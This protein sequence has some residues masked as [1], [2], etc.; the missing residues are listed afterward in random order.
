MPSLPCLISALTQA[1]GGDLLFRFASSVLLRGRRG[2]AGR[3]RCVWG[4]LAVFRPHWVCPVQGCLCF[5]VC[6]A[7]AP[8]CS[9]WS[10]PCVE[11][12]SS[13]QVLHKSTD[14]VAPAFCAFPSQS[15]SG[16]QRLGCP[17]PGCGAPFP[18]AASG[19]GSQRL[20]RTLPGCGIP[21][22]STAPACAAGW[23]P[24]ACVC[25]EELTSS[26]DPPGGGCRPSRISGSL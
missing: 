1:G 24:A 26:C 14:S 16:S 5:P 6:T 13:F 17:L 19:S 25:S 21:F 18:S 8:G 9:I 22:P 12:G 15:G 7:Q 2:A 23:V 20:G 3:C 4:A 10:G 11:C